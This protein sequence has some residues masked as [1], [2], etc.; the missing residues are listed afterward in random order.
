M[1]LAGYP[2]PYDIDNLLV[3]AVR[4][5]Y[6]PTTEPIPDSIADVIGMVSPYHALTGW[7]DI[8][9][10]KES[11]TYTRSFDTEGLEIQQ[12]TSALFEEIT[13]IART[14][15]CSLAE[16]N[17]EVLALIEGAESTPG[18]VAAAANASAQKVVK[19]GSFSTLERFRWAFISRRN[20]ASGLV[21][22]PGAGGATRGR[23]VMGV[24]NQAQLASDDA[25]IE[26]AKGELTAAGV[27]FTAFPDETVE[28][29]ADNFGAWYFENEGTIAAT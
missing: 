22:E 24:L 28:E 1:A 2:F 17:P 13:S 11:F 25:D 16:F 4:I 20:K 12:S 6:A 21:T 29:S 15:E 9:A 18:T 7:K 10:T 23:L 14:I 19:F 5:L 3:G 27:K 8:G 26:Q